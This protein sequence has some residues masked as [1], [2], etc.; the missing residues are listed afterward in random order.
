MA[1][2][3][4]P[5]AANIPKTLKTLSCRARMT[6]AKRHGGSTGH[7]WS[8]RDGVGAISLASMQNQ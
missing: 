2:T 5:A 4:T 3:A 7:R 8:F 6:L 1:A